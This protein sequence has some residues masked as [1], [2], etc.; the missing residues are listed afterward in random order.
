MRAGGPASTSHESK[1]PGRG[2]S[3]FT[4]VPLVSS[5][6]VQSARLS[7]VAMRISGTLKYIQYFPSSL[8]AITRFPSTRL[9][10][11][12]DLDSRLRYFPLTIL[13]N[14]GPCFSQ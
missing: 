4:S 5:R 10:I 6:G 8:V 14:A 1:Y 7:D 13:A 3:S 11:A 2:E 12:P 9:R